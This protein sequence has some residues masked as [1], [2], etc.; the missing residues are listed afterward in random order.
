MNKFTYLGVTLSLNGK[1]FSA[2]VM[3]RFRKALAASHGIRSPVG[4]SIGTALK[5]FHMKVSPTASY[6]IGL[7]WERLTAPDFALLDRIKP[8]FL[9]RVLGLH[10]STLNRIVYLLVGTPLYVE[11]LVRQFALR[12]TEAYKAFLR[13]YEVKL[14]SVDHG[15]YH[16]IGMTTD[17]WRGANQP[18]RHLVARMAAHGFH[19]KLC[20]KEN[21][22][23]P[24]DECVC[25]RCKLNCPRYHAAQ[26]TKVDSIADLV[27]KKERA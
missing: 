10:R 23:E 26:C 27:N 18:N 1:S 11:D 20:T 24:D 9:K 3:S 15:L 25:R 5:L 13:S 16:T 14:A 17:A 19:S 2:H 4:L 22:N 6:G 7:C 12:E 8:A 21:C